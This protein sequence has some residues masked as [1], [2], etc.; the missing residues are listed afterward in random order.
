MTRLAPGDPTDRGSEYGRL[1]AQRDRLVSQGVDPAEL[2]V[3]HPP[4]AKVDTDATPT[5]YA[6]P[7]GS[8]ADQRRATRLDPDPLHV[9]E[10][11]VRPDDDS[12]MVIV[13]LAVAMVATIAV[14]AWA[15]TR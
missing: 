6:R 7:D 4:G 10:P 12:G 14:V 1:L 8:D 2:L 3:P 9:P 5:R 13:W 11:D 15:V